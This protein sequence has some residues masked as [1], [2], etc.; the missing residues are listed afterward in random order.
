MKTMI[1]TK[2]DIEIKID[3]DKVRPTAMASDKLFTIAIPAAKISSSFEIDKV[4][5]DF[6]HKVPVIFL[7]QD[8]PIA[9][10]INQKIFGQAK[11]GL[12]LSISLEQH[13]ELKRVAETE[14]AA[15]LAPLAEKAN[16]AKI[17][18]YKYEMGCDCAD[19]NHIRYSDDFFTLPY[20]AQ[21]IRYASDNDL[22]NEIEKLPLAQIG[23]ELGAEEIESN[24]GSYGGYEFNAEQTAELIRRA[25]IGIE[26]KQAERKA[27][28][29]KKDAIFVQAKETNQPVELFRYMDDCNRPDLDCSFDSI[30]VY[31]MPD[32]RTKKERHHCY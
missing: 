13:A 8:C 29:D 30:V 1:I 4:Y 17:I 25:Q 9:A 14:Y 10:Y 22:A 23:R 16:A 7:D 12:R 26:K 21:K 5:V 11:K 19:T 2:K 3:F 18:G 31:A 20:E 24:L 28:Q 6:E 32:G 27:E 15:W